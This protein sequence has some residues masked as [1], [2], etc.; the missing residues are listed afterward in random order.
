M[1]A[2][3]CL[4]SLYALFLHYSRAFILPRMNECDAAD[5][6]EWT[7]KGELLAA[8]VV[9]LSWATTRDAERTSTFSGVGDGSQRVRLS[10]TGR[11]STLEIVRLLNGSTSSSCE[12]YDDGRGSLLMDCD[13]TQN[14]NNN[15][16]MTAGCSLKPRLHDTTRCQTCCQ[17]GLT[18]G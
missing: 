2:S 12:G 13:I 10:S 8:N 3:T 17:S 4:Y 14:N 1:L 6:G 7:V 9:R 5:D 15:N 11:N 18:T 16:V